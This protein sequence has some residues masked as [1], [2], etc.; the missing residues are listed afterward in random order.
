MPVT[1]FSPPEKVVGR[2][3]G[4]PQVPNR[5]RN[6]ALVTLA[7]VVT[8][9]GLRLAAGVMIPLILS[10]L[11]ALALNPFVSFLTRIVRS[12]AISAGITVGGLVLLLGGAGY[13]LSDDFVGA[14]RHLPEATERLRI[15]LRELRRS[16]GPLSALGQAADNIE[17][18]AREAAGRP[19]PVTT[20]SDRLWAG[21]GVREWLVVGSM[22]V[23]GFAGQFL[24]LIFFVFFLLASGDL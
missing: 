23:I 15:A 14:A 7:V 22:S 16:G 9:G 1:D 12:R 4:G 18:A 24:L 6:F 13:V 11:A 19:Q 21:L 17:A 3:T 10:I 5:L 8:L 20:V 2:E